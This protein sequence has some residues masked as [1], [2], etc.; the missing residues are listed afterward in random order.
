MNLDSRGPST[1]QESRTVP[2]RP[3]VVVIIGDCVGVSSIGPTESSSQNLRFLHRL[4]DEGYNFE[5]AVSTSYWSLP[6][7]ASLLTGAYPWDHR[8]ISDNDRLS[9]ELPTLPEVALGCGYRTAA[10]SSNPYLSSDFGLSRGFETCSAGDFVE[11]YLKGWSA[12]S[13]V[14]HNGRGEVEDSSKSAGRAS[15]LAPSF[16]RRNLWALDMGAEFL[17]RLRMSITGQDLLVSPW[18][19]GEMTRWLR[20]VSSSDP[21]FCVVNL[22]DAHEP[23]IGLR[24]GLD[25]PRTRSAVWDALRLQWPGDARHR[26]SHEKLRLEILRELYLASIEVLDRRAERLFATFKL[27]RNG[28]E[29]WLVFVGDHGQSFNGNGDLFHQFGL[30]DEVFRVPLLIRPPGGLR[31]SVRWSDWIS[32]RYLF[33][34]LSRVVSGHGISPERDGSPVRGDADPPR[35]WALS[36]M[37]ISLPD[38]RGSDGS[39]HGR[40]M[41]LVEFSKQGRVVYGLDGRRVHSSDEQPRA[42]ITSVDS[43][44]GKSDPEV[45]RIVTSLRSIEQSISER[46]VSRRVSSWGYD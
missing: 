9:N 43:S 22:M 45:D 44:D 24:P 1:P 28:R 32:I 29:P 14:S 4:S 25:V 39:H 19:E 2:D 15:Q 33:P 17:A 8:V 16:I 46:P 26:S 40:G 13:F 18:I 38:S 31:R 21:V 36:E 23:Y 37:P 7:H 6:S 35:V 27:A 3:D 30:S 41:T 34:I 12:R 11:T 10:F 42:P 20:S 5:R